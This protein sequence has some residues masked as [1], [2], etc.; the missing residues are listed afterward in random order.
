MR[1]TDESVL[2]MSTRR[3]FLKSAGLGVATAGYGTANIKN[4]PAACGFKGTGKTARNFVCEGK[5]TLTQE[6]LYQP[7]MPDEELYDLQSDPW[8]IHN[9][10]KMPEHQETLKRLRTVQEQ[11]IKDTN[12]QGQYPAAL[13]PPSKKHKPKSNQQSEKQ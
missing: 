12:D 9:L 2:L 1:R 7:R 11:W 5:L 8:E 3:E 10:V 13:P 6:L 4:L